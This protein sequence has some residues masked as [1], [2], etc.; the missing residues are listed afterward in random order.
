M[1]ASRSLVNLAFVGAALAWCAASSAFAANVQTGVDA[2]AGPAT[3]STI[4][5]SQDDR[6]ARTAA[7]GREPRGNPLWAIPLSSLAV[8]RERPLFLPSRRPPVAPA[9]AGPPVVIVPKPVEDPRPELTLVGAIAGE[10]EGF[11]IFIDLRNNA[12]VRLRTGQEHG[13]WTLSSVKG[14]EVTF[15]KDRDTIAFVLP[16]PGANGAPSAAPGMSPVPDGSAVA[17]AA[18]GGTVA[19]RDPRDFAP[20]VPRSTPKN[21]EHDGL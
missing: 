20:F 19:P 10:T 5:I 8:T 12:L 21:G 14:R 18:T 11:A 1:R 2:P 17:A 4:D 13:G 3:P 9:V 15:A 16:A 7:R 6:P